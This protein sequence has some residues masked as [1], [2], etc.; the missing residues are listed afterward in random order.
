M[1]QPSTYQPQMKQR[2]RRP[3]RKDTRVP[4][5]SGPTTNVAD[6]AVNEEMDGSLE[7]AS[8]ARKRVLNLE[9]TKTTQANEIAS[10]KK[11]AKKLKRRNKSKTYG[12]KRL[13]RVGSSRRVES[14]KDEGLGEED[15]SKQERRIHDID[16]DEDIT[17][18]NNDNEMFDV[19]TLIGDEVLAE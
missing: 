9:T 19:G 11:R 10:L 2:S 3:K 18:V 15:A 5:P 8:A 17:L 16:A 12:L 6:E 13:Y 7:R 14:F 4:Q 1:I